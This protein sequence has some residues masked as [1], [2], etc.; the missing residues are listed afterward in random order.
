MALRD[1]IR[2]AFR[3]QALGPIRFTP[4]PHAGGPGEVPHV[5]GGH[6]SLPEHGAPDPEEEEPEN[7]VCPHCNEEHDDD[8]EHVV[9]HDGTHACVNCS[10]TCNDCDEWCDPSDMQEVQP[11]RSRSRRTQNVCPSCF[12]DHYFQCA[13][14]DNNFHENHSGGSNSSDERICEGCSENYFTCEDC[15]GVF[16][17]DEYGEAGR[18]DECTREAQ[19]SDLIH[20]YGYDPDE[21]TFHGDDD[22]RHYG[23][24]L[25]TVLKKG[26]LS[27]AAEETIDKLGDDFAYLKKD[28]SLSGGVGAFEIVTHPAT[29]DVHRERW[30]KFLDHPPRGLVSHDTSCC[31]LHVHVEKEG[32]SDLEIYRIVAFVNAASN[33]EF[34]EAI[35]RRKSN[36]YARLDP[37]KK[38]KHILKPTNRYEA[39]NLQNSDT[40]EFRIFKGTL[41]KDS[42]FRSL[43]FVDGVTEWAKDPN[44]G[45]RSV[46]GTGSFFQFVANRA[47]EYPLLAAFCANFAQV[48]DARDLESSMASA[49][50][51]RT[52]RRILAGSHT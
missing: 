7:W 43:E 16:S 6:G 44:T 17:N 52:G 48:R 42:F 18:C 20:E 13:D 21:L 45:L 9:H 11:G 15:D 51:R 4:E 10:E 33:A 19:N 31:G 38:A 47:K 12:S 24:E 29:L 46:H 35:S 41:N 30:P 1:R 14:C 36:Q 8:S 3:S 39:I 23:V 32:L 49:Q 5:E 28:S 50:L 26:D 2:L 22:K 25:E 27:S 34:V 40:I 37:N